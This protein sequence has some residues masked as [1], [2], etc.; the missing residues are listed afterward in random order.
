MHAPISAPGAVT[1]YMQMDFNVQLGNSNVR[2]ATSLVTSLPVCY[3]EKS[4]PT[5]IQFFSLKKTQGTTTSHAGA[6]YTHH[7]ADRS[8]I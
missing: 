1:H 7:D 8:D 2:Y 4:R 3:Q 5:V 6:L